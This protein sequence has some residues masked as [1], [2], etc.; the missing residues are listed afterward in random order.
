M[1]HACDKIMIYAWNKIAWGRPLVSSSFKLR[2]HW[3][4]IGYWSW[5]WSR[6]LHVF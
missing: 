6:N 2:T 3:Y 1:I 5:V 4:A